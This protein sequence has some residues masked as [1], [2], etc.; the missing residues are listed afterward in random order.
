ML[1]RTPRVTLFTIL[2]TPLFFH[3]SENE[4]CERSVCVQLE[5]VECELVFLDRP[6]AEISVGTGQTRPI[7]CQNL[8]NVNKIMGFSDRSRIFMRGG[9]E[10]WLPPFPMDNNSF[11]CYT[12]PFRRSLVL[13]LQREGIDTSLP[14]YRQDN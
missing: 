9:S 6:R 8:R 12:S 4:G 11:V 5:D 1:N 13:P 3:N 14:Y 2:L 7:H 10:L